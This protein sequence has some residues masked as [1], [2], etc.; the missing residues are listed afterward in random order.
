[1]YVDLCRPFVLRN[2][3]C[4]ACHD[5][6]D[7]DICRD[8]HLNELGAEGGWRCHIE[9]CKHPYDLEAIENMLVEYF[10]R[11]LV[12]Y[13]VQDLRCNHCGQIKGGR[14]QEQHCG[15]SKTY[16]LTMTRDAEAS[17]LLILHNIATIHEMDLLRE[18]V[19]WVRPEFRQRYD[20][21]VE[22]MRLGEEDDDDNDDDD[23]GNRGFN[24][25]DDDFDDR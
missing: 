6:R 14:L 22:R 21:Y 12:A 3:S 2:V 18:M 16:S 13:N 8:R 24:D 4:S 23:E 20:N 11:N 10:Q 17:K 5:C 1:M 15:G 7:I 19:E 9:S 25:D